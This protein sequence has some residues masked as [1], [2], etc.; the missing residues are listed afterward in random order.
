MRCFS[1]STC[2]CIA[3]PSLTPFPSSSPLPLLVVQFFK[4]LLRL[5]PVS[6]RDTLLQWWTGEALTPQT[7]RRPQ[8]DCPAASAS[9]APWDQNSSDSSSSSSSEG[10][11]EEEEEGEEREEW[12]VEQGHRGAGSAVRE[13][14]M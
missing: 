13:K 14:A 12:G 2:S 11:G 9:G 4:P 6:L 5:L 3:P 10:S 8:S 7:L 1:V